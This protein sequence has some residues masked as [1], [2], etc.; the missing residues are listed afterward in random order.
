MLCVVLVNTVVTILRFTITPTTA[1]VCFRWVLFWGHIVHT[2]FPV[3]WGPESGAGFRFR[4]GFRRNLVGTYPDVLAFQKV[5]TLVPY[6]N[7]NAFRSHWTEIRLTYMRRSWYSLYQQSK[8]FHSALTTHA[9]HCSLI[10]HC[11]NGVD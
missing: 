5:G 9:N 10:Y 7:W 3:F 6:R 1:V 11:N 4:S 2:S 8:N